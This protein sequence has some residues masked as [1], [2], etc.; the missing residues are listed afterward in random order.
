MIE[1][2]VCDAHANAVHE[3]LKMKDSTKVDLLV[4]G[5][6]GGVVPLNIA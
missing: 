2:C 3:E 4:S 1:Y 6:G 5:G